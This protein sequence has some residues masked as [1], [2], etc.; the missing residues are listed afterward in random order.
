MGHDFGRSASSEGAQWNFSDHRLT[1]LF[2]W[3]AAELDN[4]ALSDIDAV[5]KVEVVSPHPKVVAG[6]ELRSGCV[7][8]RWVLLR[9][10]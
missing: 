5:V 9:R 2:A 1:H 8:H 7:G 6:C 3:S 10:C 4:L